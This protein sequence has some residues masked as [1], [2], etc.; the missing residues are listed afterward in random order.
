MPKKGS[1]ESSK[2]KQKNAVVESAKLSSNN[3][4]DGIF[5]GKKRKKTEKPV[6]EQAKSPRTLKE[7]GNEIDEIFAGKK[8]K[9]PEQ[10][11]LRGDG[12]VKKEE[13]KQKSTKVNRKK[14]V[15]DK[16]GRFTDPP[17]RSR[18]KTGDGLN[19]YTEEELG[20][21]KADAGGTRLCPFDCDC[22]F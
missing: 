8:R 16:E 17:A 6:V 3:D 10:Q 13:G 4:I 7:N 22:C 5:S 21:N 9:K 19:V 18:K 14:R 15:E 11:K 20:F 12:D 1:S 2:K